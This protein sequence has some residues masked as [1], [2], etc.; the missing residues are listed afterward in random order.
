MVGHAAYPGFTGESVPASGSPF[1]YDLLRSRIGFAGVVYTDDLT[2][3]ALAGSLA[4]RAARS[5][6]A[7]ADVLVAA[8]GIDDYAEC[9]A[10]VGEIKDSAEDAESRIANLRSRCRF[11]PRLPFTPEAWAALAD[12]VKVFLEKLEKP[13]E[14]RKDG[15]FLIAA[16][17]VAAADESF[18]NGTSSSA[19]PAAGSETAGP[20]P[21]E[22]SGRAPSIF[23]SRALISVA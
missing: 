18:Q 9:V 7:G 2:M 19:S 6:A 12:E 8:R 3:G 23:M 20:T 17:A 22:P 21:E 5:A 15:E 11:S 14:K 4:E 10:R 16:A 1:F 13:R